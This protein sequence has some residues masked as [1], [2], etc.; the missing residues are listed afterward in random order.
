[1]IDNYVVIDIETTMDHKTIRLAGMYVASLDSSFIAE[2]SITFESYCRL[3]IDKDTV[4]YTWNGARFDFRILKDVWGIDLY[5]KGKHIDGMLLAKMLFPDWYKYSLDSAA[6]TLGVASEKGHIDDYDTAPIAELSTYLLLDLQV[7][8]QCCDVMLKRHAM[9]C[10]RSLESFES[11]IQLEN[12]VA[13]LCEE[14]CQVGVRFDIIKAKFILETIETRMEEIEREVEPHLPMWP[15]PSSKLHNPPKIQFKIDGSP[16]LLIKNYAAKYGYS[17]LR[18]DGSV[19]AGKPGIA[20]RYKLPLTRPLVTEEKLTLSNQT[21]LKSWLQSIGWKPTEWNVKKD[22]SGKYVETSP[23]LTLKDTKEPCPDLKRL[24][25]SWIDLVSEWL[26]LRSRHNVIESSN[27]TG[28]LN[29]L[30]EEG[31][32]VSTVKPDADT[33]GA[34]TARW[35]HKGV[36]NIP[37]VSSPY[38]KELRSLF[39][40]RP[41]KVWVGWDA[42]SLEACMEAHYTY[43]IDKEYSKELMEGDPHTK[44]LSLI[45][46]LK[47]R[48]H[49]KTFKYGIT[50]GAQAA[51]VASILGV[52]EE[53]GK[54]WFDKFWEGNMALRKLK[55]ELEEVADSEGWIPALDGRKIKSRSKHSRLNALFQSAGAITMKY[56]MFIA[57]MEIKK[58][59]P[60]K[61]VG[62]IR[63]H[64]EEIWECDPD[65]AKEVGAIGVASIKAAG[66]YLKLNVPLDA[67]YKIGLNWAQVH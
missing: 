66:K 16:S 19:Y 44:N 4:I 60:G 3:Y 46:P 39:C 38:G 35:T 33:L 36:A 56:A 55:Q 29:S 67:E 23:R 34:N 37:R 59:Y 53:E 64:D 62:L 48:D 8:R 7:T 49:A 42:S 18:E 24:G 40:A 10:F 58:R 61:A 31:G 6:K 20:M 63:Y 65:I 15:I 28:W 41:G 21:A 25:V 14:Q 51:K 5:D 22:S 50:Y 2:D 17:L 26:M 52:S 47:D 13:E 1:M 45:G 30:T 9:P 54:Y 57:D 27:G 32:G 43:P 12:K 11:A